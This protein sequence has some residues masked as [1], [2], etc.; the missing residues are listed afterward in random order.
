MSTKEIALPAI[1]FGVFLSLGVAPARSASPAEGKDEGLTRVA[2]APKVSEQFTISA[3]PLSSALRQYAD[4]TGDQVVFFSEIGKD[5][6]SSEVNGNFTHDEALSKLLKNTGL[7]Y[8]RIAPNAIA[9]TTAS[10]DARAARLSA[11][12]LRLVQNENSNTSAA[13]AR[14]DAQQRGEGAKAQTTGSTEGT[15]ELVVT[16]QKRVERLQD[17]PV[18]VTALD[19]G[20]LTDRN[21]LRLQDYYAHVPGMA[22][23]TGS[24]G[25][26]LVSIRGISTAATP[27]VG[28]TVDDVP[29][30]ASTIIGVISPD[31][32]PSE[33]SRIEVLRGPQG[34]LYGANSMGGLVKY[35]TQDPSTEGVSGRVQV[36]SNTVQNGEGLGYSARGSVNVPLGDSW[37]VRAGGSMRRDAGY[38]DDPGQGREGV[39]ERDT[40]SVRVAALWRPA[41][42]LSL[43]LSAL[44]QSSERD[45]SPYA[46]VRAGLG[47]LQQLALPGT[48][49]FDA[50]TRAYS[51]S[52]KA[53]LGRVDLVSLSGYNIDSWST[54]TDFSR[55]FGAP[56]TIPE[57]VRTRKFTQEVRLSGQFNEHVEWLLGAFY[58]DEKTART[59]DSF[60]VDPTTGAT[61]TTL[62]LGNLPNTYEELAEFGTLTFHVTDRFDV[63]AGVR[64]SRDK[65][66]QDFLVTRPPPAANTLFP[67]LGIDEDSFTYL[68]TPQF[69]FSPEMMVY[70][71]VATGYRAGGAN[72]NGP[73]FGL[74]P[75][76]DP[77]KTKNYEIGLK[78]A[79]LE[80]RLSFDAS[81]FWIDWDHIQVQL[82]NATLAQA[83]LTNA[84]AAR[85]RGIELSAESRPLA[86]TTIAAW[87]SLNDAELTEAFPATSLSFARPGDRLPF[88]SRVSANL[89][90]DQ[91]FPI[92]GGVTGFVAALAG[93]VGKRQANFTGS[94]LA[95]RRVFP[96]FTQVDLHAGVRFGSWTANVFA[97]NL[98]DRRG[99]LATAQS[100]PIAYNYIQPR[101][102]GLA[103]A[104]EF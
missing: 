7:R 99:E 71:R 88:G 67:R 102:I 98:T 45:G 47:D 94:A 85:S 44:V 82:F 49:W 41:D 63:Q 77:D 27:T 83:Y 10:S 42:N 90:L 29:Y 3:Q 32:D 91:E 26:P 74:P 60:R 4:Q 15:E 30:G 69:K 103:I 38:V 100:N 58:A 8:E 36:S 18:P 1:L 43:Q 81:L 39:N 54:S 73:Q 72:V 93:Y 87:V 14:A 46:H 80:R 21:Q 2:D 34:T 101:T 35:V 9:I 68:L 37:G 50:D 11:T 92:A 86:G 95:V 51:A 25:E 31:F 28:I 20:T 55:N 96:A 62:S 6:K 61:V 78:G 97:N 16:A 12:A 52:F 84:G 5:Q 33:L 64:V 48:G 59:Q 40:G 56:T 53:R 19:A 23:S 57:R 75:K 104:K 70:A 17:V 79:L 13:T 66:T 65:Q 24:R 76:Y 89:S 22:L